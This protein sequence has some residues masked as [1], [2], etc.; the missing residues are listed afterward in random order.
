M[1]S[2]NQDNP[3][4]KNSPDINFKETKGNE[5][6]MSNNSNEKQFS[7]INIRRAL[8]KKEEIN[9]ETYNKINNN[10]NVSLN[11]GN[12]NCKSFNTKMRYSNPFY[13][14]QPDNKI[15]SQNKDIIEEQKQL[16]N[17]FK[18]NLI[19]SLSNDNNKNNSEYDLDLDNS[20]S[21]SGHFKSLK[22]TSENDN[23]NQNNNIQNNDINE[24]ITE[25]QNNIQ[26][27]NN[28]QNEN[29]PPNKNQKNDQNNSNNQINQNSTQNT[30]NS[31]DNTNDTEITKIGLSNL[32]NTSYLN[33]ILQCLGNIEYLKDYF[34]NE[35]NINN[36]E[37]NR[38]DMLLSF[39][40]DRV[41]IHFYSTDEEKKAYSPGVFLKVLCTKNVIYKSKNERNPNDCLVFILN[42]LNDELN[43]LKNKSEN[44]K[45]N[46]IDNKN[47]INDLLRYFYSTNNSLIFKNFNW[48]KIKEIKCI[49]CGKNKIEL[50][51]FYTLQLDNSDYYDTFGKK[52]ITI[53]DCLNFQ[54]K[55]KNRNV[56]CG[57][58]R[59]ECNTEIKSRIYIS[60]KIFVFL[61]D[62]GDFDEKKLK[63]PFY[64][65]EEINLKPY[66]EQKDYYKYELIGI[67]SINKEEKKY[68]AFCNA[69]KDQLWYYFND[70]QVIKMKAKGVIF[71]NNNNNFIPCI[72]FYKAIDEK[73]KI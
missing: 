34:L 9:K 66:I 4:E 48:F 72:L 55:P 15:N 45:Y 47:N 29:D 26:M 62:R 14:V 38:K 35:D 68:V 18:K 36:I 54:L 28:I 8:T 20:L 6:Q 10:F 71:K 30:F 3:V 11:F 19:K 13:F 1:S 70:E 5:N 23:T 43:E 65:E 60:P 42:S 32:G 63:I 24:N 58:C 57:N 22:K 41:F 21:Q 56:Y 53:K 59:M 25:N 67:V 49:N 17:S 46:S 37:T 69:F 39:V 31:L 50:N 33:S 52:T 61:L 12:D 7:D 16:H 73:T 27:Q 64:L 40:M 44:Y 51:N 2:A